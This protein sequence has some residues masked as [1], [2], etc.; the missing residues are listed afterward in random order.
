VEDLVFGKRALGLLVRALRLL[1]RIRPLRLLLLV[2]PLRLLGLLIRS[3]RGLR[4]RVL[5]GLVAHDSDSLLRVDFVKGGRVGREGARG[6]RWR[7]METD[8]DRWRPMETDGAECQA[9][10]GRLQAP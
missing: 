5:R 4:I 8:G 2:R 1:L 9:D 6:D 10:T 3:L 7:P